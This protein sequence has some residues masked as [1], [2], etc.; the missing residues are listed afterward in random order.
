F[1]ADESTETLQ[2]PRFAIVGVG[3]SAGGLEAYRRLLEV[4]PVDTGMAFVL[5]PASVGRAREHAL[6]DPRP[7]D[8]HA[9]DRGERRAEDRAESRLRDS[10]QQ[11]DVDDRWSFETS[12]TRGRARAAP[13]HR[14]VLA[15]AG[16]GPI[17][18]CDR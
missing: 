8:L 10:P 11:V 12:P 4:L 5:G 13:A 3:A 15:V 1:V 16:G 2:L 9:G 14:Y 7:G 6:D 17:A 18:S